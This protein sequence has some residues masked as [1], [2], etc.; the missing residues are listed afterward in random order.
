MKE[1]FKIKWR[2]IQWLIDNKGETINLLSK[3]YPLIIKAFRNKGASDGLTREEFGGLLS[4]LGL[5]GEKALVDK[6]F[7]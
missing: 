2:T 4:S 5:G 3:Q 6:L 1:K 7:L